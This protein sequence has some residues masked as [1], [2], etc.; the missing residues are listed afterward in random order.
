MKYIFVRTII[1]T[2]ASTIKYAKEILTDAFDIKTAMQYRA[3]DAIAA[4]LL[5]YFNEI[6]NKV[7]DIIN[8]QLKEAALAF[9]VNPP[10]LLKTAPAIIIPNMIDAMLVILTHPLFKVFF[11][12]IG[13]PHFGHMDA[14]LD[15]SFPHSGH[16]ISDIT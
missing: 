11:R 9:F 13:Y 12:G 6:K 3:E 14:I 7:P 2:I 16:L 4:I 5:L 10:S 15:I 1:P 8:S